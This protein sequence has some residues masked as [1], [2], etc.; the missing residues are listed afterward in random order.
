MPV[1]LVWIQFERGVIFLNSLDQ[2]AQREESV[3]LLVMMD[4]VLNVVRFL[5]RFLLSARQPRRGQRQRNA[6]RQP[7][8]FSPHA[9]PPFREA[10]MPRLLRQS[11]S[12][13]A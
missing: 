5:L 4:R 11:E 7:R 3:A 2:F 10:I 13:R 9:A 6:H 1:C 12:W 8:H